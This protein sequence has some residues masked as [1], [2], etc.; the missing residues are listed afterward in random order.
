MCHD[1][2][3]LQS[4]RVYDQGVVFTLDGSLIVIGRNHKKMNKKT[5]LCFKSSYKMIFHTVSTKASFKVGCESASN[6]RQFCTILSKITLG[7]VAPHFQ[8]SP[9]CFLWSSTS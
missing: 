4:V 6:E 3:I 7:T 1:V 9:I 8:S 2:I 5:F